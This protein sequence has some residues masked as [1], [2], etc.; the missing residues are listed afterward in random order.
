ME[1]SAQRNEGFTL[2]EALVAL[3]LLAIL[4]LGLLAGL[5]TSMQYNIL[6]HIRDEAKR[7]ALECAENIRST[8]YSDLTDGN[9]SCN[10][11]NPVLTDNPCA[12]IGT[13]ITNGQPEEVRRQARNSSISYTIGWSVSTVEDVK[14]IRIEVC[15][16][17]RGKSY[18][19]TVTTVRGGSSL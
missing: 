14:E 4:L 13:R 18:R 10:T 16:N 17:Y 1:V 5:L 12:N 9:V 6:N 3:A 8:P 15:W 11:P 7:L 2:I 19:H